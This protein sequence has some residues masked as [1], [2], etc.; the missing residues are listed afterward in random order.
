MLFKNSQFTEGY[1]RRPS[2]VLLSPLPARFAPEL[3]QVS[4]LLAVPEEIDRGVLVAVQ[5]RAA[6]AA[7]PAMGERH[8]VNLPAVRTACT[9]AASENSAWAG[10]PAT[11]ALAS[12]FLRPTM[13]A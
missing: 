7:H 8:G 1:R 2:R 11:Q 6:L 4:P 5:V 10:M 3:E 13:N 12:S 9:S